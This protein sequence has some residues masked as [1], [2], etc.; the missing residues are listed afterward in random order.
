MPKTKKQNTQ[1]SKY[2]KPRVPVESDEGSTGDQEPKPELKAGVR[3]KFAQISSQIDCH[4][5]SP[6]L[7][8]AELYKPKNISSLAINNK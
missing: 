2:A 1:K 3:R 6:K 5:I 4:K 7:S 8:L